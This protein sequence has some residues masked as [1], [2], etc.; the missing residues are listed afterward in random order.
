[1]ATKPPFDFSQIA[2]HVEHQVRHV[3]VSVLHS[4]TGKVH[5]VVVPED[6]PISDLHDALLAHGYQPETAKIGEV[7]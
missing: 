4:D 1:M 6:T 5:H 2:G 7:K 3:L